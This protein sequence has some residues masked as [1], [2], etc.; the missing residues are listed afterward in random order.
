MNVKS[1]SPLVFLLSSQPVPPIS[2]LVSCYF[3]FSFNLL[4]FPLCLVPQFSS[5]FLSFSSRRNIQHTE[6]KIYAA[7]NQKARCSGVLGVLGKVVLK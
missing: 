3:T 6:K 4:Y 5:F 7:V 1:G 2:P